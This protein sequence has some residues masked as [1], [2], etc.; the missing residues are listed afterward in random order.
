MAELPLRLPIV[1]E[2][3]VVGDVANGVTRLAR[4][5]GWIHVGQLGAALHVERMLG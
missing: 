3:D 2:D 1:P 4:S 5:F